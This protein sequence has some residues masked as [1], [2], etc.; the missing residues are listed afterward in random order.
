MFSKCCLNSSFCCFI[1]SFFPQWCVLHFCGTLDGGIE[2]LRTR[3]EAR[4]LSA[5]LK[6][7]VRL[8]EHDSP[9]EVSECEKGRVRAT[10]PP[11]HKRGGGA[12]HWGPMFTLWD[13]SH[14]LFSCAHEEDV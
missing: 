9:A 5:E 13:A 8:W 1:P 4:A 14:V 10:R 7:I 3:E 12:R 11:L 6:G 2:T